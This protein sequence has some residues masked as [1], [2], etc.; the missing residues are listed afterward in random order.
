MTAGASWYVVFTHPNGEEAAARHL[1]RQGFLT[2]LPRRWSVRRHAR[3]QE[4]VKRP[5]FPRYLFVSLD[6]TRQRWRSVHSTI[7]VTRLVC[8]GDMPAPVPEGVVERLMEAQDDNGCIR[9]FA[10]L[11]PGDRVRILGGVFADLIGLYEEM[12]DANRVT[13]LL[14]LLGRQVRAVVAPDI[15]EAAR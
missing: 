3:R 13:L 5:L 4:R 7:G 8:R 1:G 2:Y 11:K 9:L 12:T 14:N 6:V 10:S 15:L